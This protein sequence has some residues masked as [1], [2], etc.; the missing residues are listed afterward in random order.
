MKPGSQASL[1]R[2]FTDRNVYGTGSVKILKTRHKIS[3]D[4]RIFLQCNPSKR[5]SP[6][7]LNG[8]NSTALHHSVLRI[9]FA[10]YTK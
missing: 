1:F 5:A 2:R 10:F 6:I 8:G 4:I 9:F 7:A 3:V